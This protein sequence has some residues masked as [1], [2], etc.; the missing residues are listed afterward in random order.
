[1]QTFKRLTTL[2]TTFTFLVASLMAPAHAA[3][4]STSDA[5]RADTVD[6]V[7]QAMHS[8]AVA[9]QLA[10]HG[11]TEAQVEARIA[12]LS[13][14]ELEALAANFDDVP[15]GADALGVRG[16]VFLVLLILEL[17]SVV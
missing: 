1:M 3:M 4:I 5:L 17:V 12:A 9:E 8:S 2:A 13:D 15:A 11:V 7:T 6:H 14:A 10:A 16:V